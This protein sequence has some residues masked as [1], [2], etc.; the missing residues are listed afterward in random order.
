MTDI[1]DALMTGRTSDG[2]MIRRPLSPHLQIYK[3]QITSG[4]SIFHRITGVALGAGTLLLV[5]W[6]AAAS[7]SDQA[8]ASVS[9]F[10]RSP[11]GYVLLF[12]WTIALWFHFCAGIRH[13]FWDAGYGYALPQ[14]Y[15]TARI[16][17]IA[18]VVLTLA[19]WAGL[20]AW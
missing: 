19:T 16:V 8:Y 10:L 2:R 5:W 15:A 7:S 3:P 18:T 17:L 14:V 13:L 1:R 4:L 12:G 20:L 6:L 11:V 9:Q